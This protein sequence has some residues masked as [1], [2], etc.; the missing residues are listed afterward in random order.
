MTKRIFQQ[1]LRKDVALL[2][3]KG[4]YFE[5]VGKITISQILTNILKWEQD[6]KKQNTIKN[7]Y[8]INKSLYTF[9][10]SKNKLR[11]ENCGN[12]SPEFK[13]LIYKRNIGFYMIIEKLGFVRIAA[14]FFTKISLK[15][16]PFLS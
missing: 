11:K 6:S 4:V 16:P 12:F 13:W 1:I 10:I 9:I 5:G 15:A 3:K 7:I 8:L 14:T 2:M